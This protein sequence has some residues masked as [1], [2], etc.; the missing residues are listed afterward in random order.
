ML[1]ICPTPI[2][3][4]DDLSIRQREALSTADIIACEDTRHT[5]KLLELLEIN[6]PAPKLISYHEHNALERAAQL[7]EEVSQ[8]KQVV[9]V[10]DAGTPTISDPGYRLVSECMRRDLEITALPGPVAGIVALSAS[11]LPTDR[12][13]FEGFLPARANARKERLGVL[14]QLG[15]TTILY[16]S[17]HRLVKMMGDL[18][19]RNFRNYHHK[20]IIPAD[21]AGAR[22]ILDNR[23]K[24][25]V[26][27]QGRDASNR[28][29]FDVRKDPGEKKNLLQAHPQVADA[30]QQQ[31]VSWQQSVLKSLT[32]A[33]YR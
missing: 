13:F 30:L 21:F 32:G 2:G 5:G 1:I 24:L 3:N 17:P 9:L 6:D 23:Y 22:V 4:L 16:E 14:R 26:N 15:V 31:L 7:A 27:G 10:S 33:D 29:L 28:E 18:Y 11:G 25:V 19:T 8:G 12:F 20:Q